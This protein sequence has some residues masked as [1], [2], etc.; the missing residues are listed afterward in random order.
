MAGFQGSDTQDSPKATM[1]VKR[2]VS[3]IAPSNAGIGAWGIMAM[4][5]GIMAM[6]AVSSD[7]V[8]PCADPDDFDQAAF[9][10]L[11]GARRLLFGCDQQGRDA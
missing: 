4:L 3:W 11:F 8:P 9:E 2:R 6:A 5:G 10:G 1:L 7:L